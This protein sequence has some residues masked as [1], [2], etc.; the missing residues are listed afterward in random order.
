MT[1]YG[2]HC[3]HEQFGPRDLLDRVVEA[4]Q[5]GFSCVSASDHFH[6]WS[7]RQGQSGFV[8]SWLGAVMERTR[9]PFR[10]VSAPGYRHHPALLA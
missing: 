5:S 10:T 3:S 1:R 4:E 8:W 9:L 2:Y 7:E 6:P